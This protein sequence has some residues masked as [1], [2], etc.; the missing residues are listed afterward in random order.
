MKIDLSFYLVIDPNY[1]FHMNWLD[2]VA[3]AVENGV[4]LV[5]YR[6]KK[7]NKIEL[8][9]RARHLRKLCIQ[10]NV[11][12]IIND[13]LDLAVAV[14]ADGV[15]LG[16]HDSSIHIARTRL[17]KDKIVGLSIE[18]SDQIQTLVSQKADYF[19][20]GPV[21]ATHSKEDAAPAMGIECLKQC[22]IKS[23]LPNVAIGG[24]NSDNIRSV[25]QTGVTG[26]AVI[27][28]ICSQKNPSQAAKTLCD[29]ISAEKGMMAN[30]ARH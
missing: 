13:Y 2:V 18:N 6:D 16:Q 29:L 5:Q 12:L 11:P 24:I 7:A 15:H 28:E 30:E 14:C 25:L 3:S 20:F 17:G 21:F 23:H 22:V 4:T 9:Q 19:G 1:C 10:K 27:S 8:V 26:I